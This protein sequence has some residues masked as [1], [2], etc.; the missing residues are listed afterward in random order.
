MEVSSLESTSNDKYHDTSKNT[1]V[2]NENTGS[3][4]GSNESNPVEGRT[5]SAVLPQSEHDDEKINNNDDNLNLDDADDSDAS[6]FIE[7]DNKNNGAISINVYEQQLD[8]EDNAAVTQQ[9]GSAGETAVETDATADDTM[10]VDEN[11]ATVNNASSSAGQDVE[12]TEAAADEDEGDAVMEDSHA[13]QPDAHKQADTNDAAATGADDLLQNELESKDDASSAQASTAAESQLTSVTAAN[14]VDTTVAVANTTKLQT[15]AAAPAPQLPVMKG[16]LCY[17]ENTRRHLIRGNWNYENSTAFPPQRFELYRTLSPDEELTLLPQDGEFH[18][19]FSLMYSHITSKGKK[20]ER[21]KVIPESGVKITYT[22]QDDESFLLDGKG[23]N[24]F[25]VFL[26]QGTATPNRSEDPNSPNYNDPTYKIEMRKRYEE[27]AVPA[28][29]TSDGKTADAG[30]AVVGVEVA[31]GP[32]PPP[33]ESFPSGVICLRGKMVKEESVETLGASEV[34]H[35]IS[36]MWA[37]GL[38]FLNDG[39]PTNRF[40]YEHK[41]SGTA[42]GIF[43]VSGRYSGWFDLTNDDGTRTRI[44]ER[45]VTLK[46]RRNN[47]GGYNVEG[48]GTNVF[49]KYNITG[50]LSAEPDNV[51]T[52]FRHFQ[53]RKIKAKT[54]VPPATASVGAPAPVQ[55]RPSLA[56]A[57]EP[58]LSLDDVVTPPEAE[59]GSKLEPIVPP[60][61]GGYSAV[62]RGVLRVNEDG[63]HTCAGKWAVTR[64]SFT[65]G[66]ISPCTF[67]LESHFAQ[68][69]AAASGDSKQFPLDSDRY[70]GNFQIKK[71][72]SRYQ[73]IIDQQVVMKFRLNSQGSYNVYGKGINPIGTFSL[74][75][76]LVMSGKTGGQVELY[77]MYPTEQLAVPAQAKVAAVVPGAPLATRPDA[78][79]R[80]PSTASLGTAAQRRESTRLVKLPSK[81]EDDDPD[82]LLTRTMIMCAQILRAVR[83]KDTEMGNFFAE[84]VD[85]V[86]LGIPSYHQIIKEPMDLKTIHRR[87]E[88]NAVSDP[89]ELAR[90]V[91][92]V[93]QNAMTFNVDPAH[94]VHQ[95]AR[96]LLVFF[97]Q[98][99]REVERI[100]VKI[101]DEEKAKKGKD[102]KKRKRDGEPLKS[103]KRMRL[104]EAQAMAAA[105]ANFFADIVSSTSANGSTVSRTEFNLLLGHIQQLSTQLVD[106]H[107]LLAEL[108]PGDENDIDDSI[109]TVYT[110]PPSS[111]SVASSAPERKKAQK[112]KSETAYT[113]ERVAV[114]DT[115]PLTE[116]EQELLT[117]NIGLLPPD[118]LDA[119][120]QI[121]REATPLEADAGDIDLEIDLLDV[122]TQRKLLRYVTKFMKK[123]KPKPKKKPKTTGKAPSQAT[124]STTAPKKSA[125]A[126]QQPKPD[127][128]SFFA[129]G[130]K[131]DD[132]DSD[133]DGDDAK[134]A[135][136]AGQ[137]GGKQ[138][139]NNNNNAAKEFRL[140]DGFGELADDNEDD[141]GNGDFA[142]NWSMPTAESEKNNHQE[143][144]DEDDAWGAA[145]ERAAMTKQQEADRKAREE[146]IKAEADA[147]K[148]Q[149]LKE[150]AARGEEL[151]AQRAEEE[152]KEALAKELQEKEAKAAA[153][154]LR[155][156]TRAQTQSVAQT[157]DLEAQRDMMKQYEQNY[158]DKDLG[159]ASPSSD[160]GF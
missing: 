96:A 3:G 46:F 126:A 76:T 140:G 107:K 90:L 17:E 127:S 6:K 122:K 117:E 80:Q 93:F 9:N 22:K 143:D 63:T 99:F 89:D 47:A 44:N 81:L 108:S 19:S 102:D 68:A 61:N 119:V 142:A 79:V 21:S 160:F 55:R 32:L 33:S 92:L 104:E 13:I 50:T 45:D 15:E 129:F 69:A 11:L 7:K 128:G 8:D 100:M 2:A 94:S 24:Q 14:S 95:A 86:A 78:L 141:E 136:A 146:R 85:P 59:N 157:V 62:M 154:K 155:E 149:R 84:P 75:G 29:T 137:F 135:Q 152:E 52:I 120:V 153:L 130:S 57:M 66:Q 26:I 133:S 40:E 36:G 12:M 58:I 98:K 60:A 118:E 88:T 115:K 145:R 150:A 23:T 101:A 25:G 38:N 4:E 148:A 30:G 67:R 34:V 134:I 110:A 158:L 27:A 151:K 124:T 42:A 139:S 147:A 16:T 103:A 106:T 138:F 54:S 82:A 83:E 18:G 112:R 37:A 72:G 51:L 105:N 41:S 97:N 159:S 43:P 111:A 71:Q 10:Q 28:A 5:E 91:R 113:V 131:G 123:S 114:E 121:I 73:T 65:G 132:S 64:E 144:D 125:A 31:E 20:K 77:R 109:T 156:A 49:G 70:K 53:P 35:K 87:M 1:L 48:R 74:L 56:Q 116:E 39:G